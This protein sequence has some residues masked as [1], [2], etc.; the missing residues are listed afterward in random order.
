MSNSQC[1]SACDPTTPHH[2]DD[3]TTTTK[4]RRRIT[5]RGLFSVMPATSTIVKSSSTHYPISSWNVT[6]TV[7]WR[8]RNELRDVVECWRRWRQIAALCVALTT[9]PTHNIE[10]W[11]ENMKRVMILRNIALLGGRAARNRRRSSWSLGKSNSVN[12]FANKMSFLLVRYHNWTSK[13]Q[14]RREFQIPN[15]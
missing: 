8:C 4:N 15:F 10:K 1:R 6:R 9:Y 11:V 5:R 12:C 3:V 13:N 7:L 14:P 2:D